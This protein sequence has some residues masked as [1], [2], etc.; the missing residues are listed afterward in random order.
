MYPFMM[1]A[2]LILHD[3]V[4]KLFWRKLR[5]EKHVGKFVRNKLS[6]KVTITIHANRIILLV[7]RNSH[8]FMKISKSS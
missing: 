5:I 4:L 7:S 3:S 1:K 8:W 6:L 2:V